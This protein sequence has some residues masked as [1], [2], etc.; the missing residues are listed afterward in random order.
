MK[1]KLHRRNT[2]SW[3]IFKGAV[4]FG[5]LPFWYKHTLLLIVT[6]LA[7]RAAWTGITSLVGKY[8]HSRLRLDIFCH[9]STHRCNVS[10]VAIRGCSKG[11]DTSCALTF[12][13]VLAANSINTKS[14]N[15]VSSIIYGS[16]TDIG[17]GE[18]EAW[19]ACIIIPAHPPNIPSQAMA[20]LGTG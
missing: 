8:L 16:R 14:A 4:V 6:D 1:I 13:T 2:H 3:S 15:R 7:C 18:E 5:V 12:T 19:F 11:G 17:I 9:L 10:T 20:V